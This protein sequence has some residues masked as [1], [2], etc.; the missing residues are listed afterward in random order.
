MIW[1]NERRCLPGR[2]C[3]R[4]RLM[5]AR[6]GRVDRGLLPPGSVRELGRALGGQMKCPDAGRS[7]DDS[8]SV[9]RYARF[10]RFFSV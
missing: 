8:S 3:G 9:G 6:P 4:A 7:W 2:T 1:P 10:E 5:V